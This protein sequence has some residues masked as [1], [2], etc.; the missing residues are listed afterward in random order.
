MNE[1]GNIT[2]LL[3]RMSE[4]DSDA[5]DELTPM[6][7]AELHRMASNHFRGD[8]GRGTL[9]PTAIVNEAYMQLAGAS[10]DLQ[11]RKHFFA[12]A[13]RMMHRIIV[14]HV[15]ARRAAKRGGDVPEVT[16]QEGLI[17]Q[18]ARGDDVLELH[19]AMQALADVDA[20]QAELLEFFY[21]GGL[22][23]EQIGEIREISPATVKRKLRFA[24]A[25]INRFLTES[26]ET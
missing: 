26:G 17:A 4:G 18:E 10:V 22:T 21:F 19:E 20:E 12:L 6:V 1:P 14:N 13:S 2:L 7:Y 5:L 9:Q 15:N 3:E 16:F 24:R 11:S 23:Y 8:R 25:W